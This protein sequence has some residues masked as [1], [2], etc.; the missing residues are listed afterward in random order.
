MSGLV[1]HGIFHALVAFVD[2]QD[3]ARVHK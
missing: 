1:E 2:G 3:R